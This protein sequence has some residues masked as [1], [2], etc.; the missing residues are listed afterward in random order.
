MR[1]RE[2][3]LLILYFD[4]TA[5]RDTEIHQKPIIFVQK[6]FIALLISIL[7]KLCL[8]SLVVHLSTTTTN[9]WLKQEVL[10]EFKSDNVKV[11]LIRRGPNSCVVLC[12][13]VFPTHKR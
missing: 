11:F 2:S 4:I 3:H 7:Y 6:V 5:I 9:F 13:Q 1:D 10:K 8:F 12:D